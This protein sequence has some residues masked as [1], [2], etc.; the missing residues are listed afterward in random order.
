MM[1]QFGRG[2][3]KFKFIAKKL[4][5]AIANVEEWSYKWGFKF[6]VEK[7]KTMFFTRKIISNEIK[8]E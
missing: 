7:T 4:Q 6:S 1:G 2:G 3:K 5:G 8:L